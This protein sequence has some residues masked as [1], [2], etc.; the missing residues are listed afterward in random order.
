MKLLRRYLQKRKAKKSGLRFWSMKQIASYTNLVVELPSSLGETKLSS[1]GAQGKPSL[2][3]AYSYMRSGELASVKSVGRYCSIGQNVI[4][5]QHPQNH[6]IHW[7]STSREFV[8]GYVPPEKHTVIGHDVWIGHNVVIMAGVEIGHG[9]VVGVSSVVT[10]DVKPYEVVA[11]IPAK[12]IRYRFSEDIIQHLL[13][14]KWWEADFN[15]LKQQDMSDIA[16]FLKA[17]ATAEK[18]DPYQTLLLQN[19]EIRF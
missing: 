12:H 4:I 16:H 17:M 14:S 8:Q 19:K 10:K 5:G 7:A 15:A 13:G 6:P 11:G 18:A 1:S 9:A 2:F 3:G